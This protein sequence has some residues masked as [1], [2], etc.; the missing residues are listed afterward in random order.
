[1]TVSGSLQCERH[2]QAGPLGGLRCKRG[3]SAH[4]ERAV[5]QVNQHTTSL[6]LQVKR[7][8]PPQLIGQVTVAYWQSKAIDDGARLVDQPRPPSSSRA[9]IIHRAPAD[10]TTRPP[11]PAIMVASPPALVSDVTT[12]LSD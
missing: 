12:G 6:A 4:P 5:Q 8:S 1:M 7:G 3:G 10:A 9:L 11:R 2:T